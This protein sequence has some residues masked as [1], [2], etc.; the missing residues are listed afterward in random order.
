MPQRITN[1]SVTVYRDGKVQRLQPNTKFDFT[2]DEVD[3]INRAHNGALRKVNSEADDILDLT[4]ADVSKQKESAGANGGDHTN[5]S[6][7]KKETA[8]TTNKTLTAAQ[9]KAQD[10]KAEKAKL[11]DEQKSSDGEEGD[12]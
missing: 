9:K 8:D 12:L 2:A 6:N 5:D 11:A 10:A 4:K 7:P 3:Q 1:I